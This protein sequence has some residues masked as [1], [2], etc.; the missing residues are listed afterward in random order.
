MQSSPLL[1]PPSARL[2]TSHLKAALAACERVPPLWPL[3]E[4]VA[5][6]PFLGFASRSFGE[7]CEILHKTSGSAPLIDPAFYESRYRSGFITEEDLETAAR[8]A[9]TRNPSGQTTAPDAG[10]TPTLMKLWLHTGQ[11]APGNAATDGFGVLTIAAAA[12]DISSRDFPAIIASLLSKFCA[13]YHDQGQAVW[14]FPWSTLPLFRAWQESAAIDRAPG[15]RGLTQVQLLA[16]QLPPDAGEAVA[17]LLEEISPPEGCVEDYCHSLLLSFFGWSSHIQFRARQNML[18][19][20]EDDSMLHLLAI[21]LAHE[22]ALLR[23]PGLRLLKSS[24]RAA[25][26]RHLSNGEAGN[27]SCHLAWQTALEVAHQRRLARGLSAGANP[28]SPPRTPVV[29]TVFCIDTRSEIFRRS[30]EQVA[31]AVETHGFAGFFGVPMEF[32]PLGR[33]H[34]EAHCPVLLQPKF[35]VMERPWQTGEEQER[36]ILRWLVSWRRARHAWNAFK[37]SAVS[38]FSFV[39]TVGLAMIAKLAK[40]GLFA[41]AAKTAASRLRTAP[42]P[43]PPHEGCCSSGESGETVGIPLADRI[44]LG[45]SILRHSGLGDK[46]SPLVL[47]CGHGASTTNNPYDASYHCGACGGHAGDANARVAAA[48]LNDPAVRS[49]LS[50]RGLSIPESTWFIAGLHDTTTDTVNLFDKDIVPPALRSDVARLESWLDQAGALARTAR[51]AALGVSTGYRETL[52]QLFHARA[53]DWSQIRP[54]L[55]LAGNAAFI[56]APRSRTAGLNLMGRAFLHTYHEDMDHDGA[57]LDLILSAPMV[58]ASWINLQYYGST[59]N[60]DLFGSGNKVL[61]NIVGTVGVCLGNQGDLRPGLPLQAIHDG[62]RLLHEPVRLSVYI[63]TTRERIDRSLAR[64][65]DVRQLADNGWIHLFVIEED[66]G[67]VFRYTG[68]HSWQPA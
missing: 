35:R 64:L 54:E 60:N 50:E 65:P 42:H 22:V 23:D 58:V 44:E 15:L 2:Q 7:A 41:P 16:G 14:R 59:V 17:L 29:Q 19:G 10:L 56:A 30:L 4:F 6:N 32:I 20:L 13:A 55:G 66:G 47:L 37:T 5:V 46:L 28:E 25:V 21:L 36:D 43:H 11:R 1:T 67:A 3:G 49:E 48:I 51:S 27:L 9:S 24:W 63:E 26:K 31:P 57:T 45:A 38:C 68:G 53:A 18:A 62:K 34:G 39:E 61:H 12:A 8:L 40:G 52:E 33:Q